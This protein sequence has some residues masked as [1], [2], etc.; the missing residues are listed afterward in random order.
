MERINNFVEKLASQ[1]VEVNDVQNIYDCSDENNK[2]RKE[3]L[4]LYLQNMMDKKSELLLVGEAPGWRGCRFTGVPFTSEN[5]LFEE[6]NPFKNI[7]ELIAGY[8]YK[9]TNENIKCLK[10]RTATIMWTGLKEAELYKFNPLLWN[11][12]PF[13]PYKKGNIDSNRNNLSNKEKNIGIYFFKEIINIFNIQ[14]NSIVAIG[15]TAKEVIEKVLKNE[16]ESNR[17]FKHPSR[18]K[19][20]FINGLKSLSLEIKNGH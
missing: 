19:L 11:A 4:K 14:E 3:N 8:G 15:D 12:L 20:D 9:K 17:C 6:N 1:K 18:R 16:M 7:F 2:I 13:H 10:E 5:I